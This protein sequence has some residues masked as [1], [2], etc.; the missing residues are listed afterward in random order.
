MTLL[1]LLAVLTAG[2]SGMGTRMTKV[3]RMGQNRGYEIAAEQP[4]VQRA[5]LLVL[6]AR[7]YE[8]STKPDPE[9]GAEGAGVI[10]IGQK[11]AKYSAEPGGAETAPAQMD[12]RE[13]VN[14]YLSKKWQLSSSQAAPNITLVDI[15]GG[16]YL[17]KAPSVD[18]VETPLTKPFMALL[19]D[20]IE[21]RVQASGQAQ[22]VKP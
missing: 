10:V 17:R 13:L 7:G 12:T 19:R 22:A 1:P 3:G 2:C 4:A 16:S 5:T 20:D 6:Q 11:T 15:V 18:E 21:R 8:T 14:V 9:N